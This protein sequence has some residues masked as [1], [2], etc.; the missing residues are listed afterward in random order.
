MAVAKTLEIISSS[1]ESIEAAVRD[2]VSK[3]AETVQG[4]QEAW[5]Q[6]TKAVIRDNKVAEWR[7]TLRITFIVS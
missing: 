1:T 3:A 4:M 6:G 2:G 5:V 7:V